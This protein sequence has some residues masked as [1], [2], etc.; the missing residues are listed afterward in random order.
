[1]IDS[2]LF[3]LNRLFT[4]LCLVFALFAPGEL[5]ARNDSIF[6]IPRELQERREIVG[7][8]GEGEYLQKRAKGRYGAQ[9][10]VNSPLVSTFDS[11]KATKPAEKSIIRCVQEPLYA[12]KDDGLVEPVLAVGMPERVSENTY[13]IQLQRGVFFH[14]GDY[15]EAK[16]VVFTINRLL[17]SSGRLPVRN[18]FS[19]IIS[20]ED[21][22]PYTVKFVLKDSYPTLVHILTEME[23]FPLSKKAVLEYGAGD[24]GA[25]TLVGTGPFLAY[26]YLKD[27]VLYL[28]RNFQY[29]FDWLPY[30]GTV[31]FEFYKDSKKSLKHLLK[32]RASLIIGPDRQT[33]FLYAK[34][35][36]NLVYYT[37]NAG[38]LQQVYLN[39]E[40]VPF[41]SR[42]I[43]KAFT[44]GINRQEIIDK[45]FNGVADEA[46]GIMPNWM[47]FHDQKMKDA[48]Y[49]QRAAKRFLAIDGYS[50]EKPVKVIMLCGTDKYFQ[51]QA[52]L[53]KKQLYKVGI[54]LEVLI[55]TKKALLSYLYGVGGKDRSQFQAALEDWDGGESVENYVYY[56][57]HSKSPY[58][59][60]RFSSAVVDDKLRALLEKKP[61]SEKK[62]LYRSIE[63]EI[64]DDENTIPICFVKPVILGRKNIN[65]IKVHTD[66][67]IDLKKAWK[68][69][70]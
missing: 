43:R 47:F 64:V 23:T 20:V 61:A 33:I 2:K 9:L 19:N 67:S 49:D 55:T 24:Y 51:D 8:E 3:L 32:R 16:D 48:Q 15:F 59:K 62:N 5:Y 18:I 70:N 37:G 39:T 66:G 65:G 35:Y 52:K 68:G 38:L 40:T 54:D 6:A 21:M 12:Y 10:T 29:R 30:Y 42:N 50:P 1:M 41:V 69:N 27:T 4:F 44:L 63:W 13:V 45:V 46:R 57:Y 34:K 53:I 17:G 22:G 36:R 14:N 7:S 58:N 11:Q 60:A 31:R 26:E 25:F 28:K 56:L